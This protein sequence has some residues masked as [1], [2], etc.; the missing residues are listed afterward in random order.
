MPVFSMEVYLFYYFLFVAYV[1][2]AIVVVVTA[3]LCDTTFVGFATFGRCEM[4]S[5]RSI[6]LIVVGTLAIQL[7]YLKVFA[8]P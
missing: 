4:E 1:D 6:D 5:I 3:L 8:L 7:F 2:N